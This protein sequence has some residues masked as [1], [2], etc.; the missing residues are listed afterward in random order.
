[1]LTAGIGVAAWLCLTVIH[2]VWGLPFLGEGG[3][4]YFDENWGNGR[5]ATFMAGWTI[6]KDLPLVHKMLGAGPDCFSVYAY[7]IPELSDFLWQ[8]FGS[9]RLTNAHC[10]LFT[11]LINTGI[12]GVIFYM[13][14]FASFIV[15]C[16]KFGK[17]T[18]LYYVFAVC[19]FCYFIHNMVSFAQVLNLP[20][21]FLLMG[22]GE[23]LCHEEQ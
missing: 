4:L 2:T 15:R 7:G 19:A 21:V 8:Q 23:S 11:L 6:W 13:G 3:S 9:A 17:G 1:M 22:M 20:F 18:W 14:I 10:E 12:F 5:G 16:L